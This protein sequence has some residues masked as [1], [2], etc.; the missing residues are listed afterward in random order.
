MYYSDDYFA[1][2]HLLWWC[3]WGFLLVWIFFLP[4][5]IPGERRPKDKPE[6]ILRKRLASGQ[7]SVEEY[8]ERKRVLEK[9]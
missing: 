8:R 4:F 7:I 6:D 2:M 5:G 3:V 1:G 9:G